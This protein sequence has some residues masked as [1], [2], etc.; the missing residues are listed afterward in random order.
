MSAKLHIVL[1][2][3]AL[4]IGT[5]AV[6]LQTPLYSAYAAKSGVGATAVT[7]AF[8]AYVAGLMPTLLFLG[9]LSD[10]IGRRIPVAVA[11]ALGVLATALLVM[12]PNWVSLFFAR[13]LLGIGTGLIT[14]AGTAYMSEIMEGDESL[15]APLI[16]TSATSLGFGSG[17][18]AT[19][20]SLKVQGETLL[21]ASFIIF[22]I[23]ALTVILLMKT[24]PL[25]LRRRNV[26]LFRFPFYPVNTS[27]YGLAMSA[28]WATTGMIIAVIPLELTRLQLNEYSGLVV[29]LAIFVG[30]LCQPAAKRC[31]RENALSSGMIMTVVGFIVILGG[32]WTSSISLILI[33]TGITSASSYGF[34]YLS[35]L[36]AF[37]LTAG[38]EKARAT[39]GLFVYAYIGFSLPVIASGA[40]ADKYGL[41]PAITIFSVFQTV[42]VI[43]ILSLIKK[44]KIRNINHQIKS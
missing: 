21:P 41:E 17:A 7:L 39:A 12:Y 44:N 24:M 38:N 13:V 11:L 40:L 20:I 2:T 23:I 28:A 37:S 31:S 30:F 29:F 4:F 5:F 22:F 9:G 25:S 1:L 32:I 36:S 16:V 6:N 3:I 43:L 35:S 42:T 19:S 26:S 34:T 15:R 8:A 27:V 18:L 14:T 10:R 33:G